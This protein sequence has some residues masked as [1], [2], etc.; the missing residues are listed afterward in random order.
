MSLWLCRPGEDPEWRYS[1][2]AGGRRA[3]LSVQSWILWHS[4]SPIHVG[5][6]HVRPVPLGR[7]GN[8]GPATCHSWRTPSLLPHCFQSPMEN[9]PSVKKKRNKIKNT[10]SETLLSCIMFNVIYKYK[11]NNY[12]IAANDIIFTELF[13]IVFKFTVGGFL[14][15]SSIA[16]REG[17][18]TYNIN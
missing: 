11:K 6:E 12:N 5:K 10:V 1:L 13:P 16:K 2:L 15:S 4:S 17:F 14:A 18:F 8:M 9:N 7:H 3:P